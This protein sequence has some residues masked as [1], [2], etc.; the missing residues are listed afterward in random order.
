MSAGDHAQHVNLELDADAETIRGTLQY[1]DGTR[2][3]FWG[4]LELMAALERAA[5]RAPNSRE[6]QPND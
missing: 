5:N 1:S 3:R 6:M 4:W 2:E